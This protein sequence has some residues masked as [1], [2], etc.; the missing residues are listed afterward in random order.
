M[1]SKSGPGLAIT[2][3][4]FVL[5]L[6]GCNK[7]TAS[8]STPPDPMINLPKSQGKFL[9]GVTDT[10][11]IGFSES[12]DTA[13]LTL[14]FEPKEGIAWS[15]KGGTG[16][17]IFGKNKAHGSSYFNINSPF[18]ATLRG[19]KDAAGNGRSDTTFSFQPYLWIDR[20]EID[21]TFHGY[22]SLFA[23]DTTWVG[24]ARI[25]DSLIAEGALD[26]NETV[27]PIDYQDVKLV[28]V[29]AGDTLLADLTTRK[30]LN[31]TFKV[32]GPFSPV[33]FDSTLKA[34]DLNK[35]LVTLTTGT[36]GSA[37][38]RVGADFGAFRQIFGSAD[39]RAIYVLFISVPQFSEGFYRV[40]VRIKPF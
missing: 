20:D 6:M 1:G 21:T 11:D 39:A 34:F 26:F 17:R 4:G 37:Y 14:D 38:A 36:S 28:K 32:A 31:L 15:F 13:S 33:G 35:A 10:L 9:F 27:G 23:T 18:T 8:D 12:I 2:V 22:D 25:S 30:D 19:L 29:R 3:L 7:E 5:S 40:G 16:V 24:G